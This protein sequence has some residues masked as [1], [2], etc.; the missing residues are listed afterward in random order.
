MARNV[1][2][3]FSEE[4]DILK[5]ANFTE[6]QELIDRP[7]SEVPIRRPTNISDLGNIIIFN[8]AGNDEEDNLMS[9]F[10]TSLTKSVKDAEVGEPQVIE[11][12]EEHSGVED[13]QSY[14]IDSTRRLPGS[15]M[16]LADDDEEDK[17][18][19]EE[20]PGTWKDDMDINDFMRYVKEAYSRIPEH[21]GTTILGCE[22]A[23]NYLKDLDRE[24]SKAISLD[25]NLVLDVGL[26]DNYRVNMMNDM[27]TL[28]SH[29]KKLQREIRE[30]HGK[31]ASEELS[32]KVAESETEIVKEATVARPQ[33][34][35]TPFERAISGMIINSVISA[36]KPFEEVYDLL[37]DK[38]KLTDREELSIIQIVTDMGY[39]IF[40][41]RG[42]I[43]TP[44]LEVDFIK[45]YSA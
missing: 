40:K 20:T 27:M 14:A 17:E 1:I 28:K 9:D 43:G 45:N 32:T 16:S 26:L 5:S 29:I 35:I 31:K 39:P 7:A 21:D 44:S 12:K 3:E 34:I 22:R 18:P 41:D 33:M 37:K 42:S 30:R 19:A 2:T 8:E 6:F 25:K 38:Y 15:S 10:E 13:A 24:V 23:I 36:G 4:F 11:F